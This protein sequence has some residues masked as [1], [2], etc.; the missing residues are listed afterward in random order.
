LFPLAVYSVSPFLL[1]TGILENYVIPTNIFMRLETE[2]I[3]AIT[4]AVHEYDPQAQIYL[5]GSRTD[6]LA[7]GGDIDILVLSACLTFK[8]K[9]KIKARIFQHLDDQ[10]IDIVIAPDISDPFIRLAK[11]NGVVL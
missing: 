5:F 10:K 9:L 3:I 6:D 4:S 2:E 7:K 8:D 11:E 1:K